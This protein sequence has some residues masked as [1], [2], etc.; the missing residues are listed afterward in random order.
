MKVVIREQRSGFKGNYCLR[1]LHERLFYEY[2][3]I[4]TGKGMFKLVQGSL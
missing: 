4:S 2:G 3:N 1:K